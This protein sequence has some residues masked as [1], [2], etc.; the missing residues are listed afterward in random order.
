MTYYFGLEYVEIVNQ[1]GKTYTYYRR[2]RNKPRIRL[3]D[4]SAGKL[5]CLTAWTAAQQNDQPATVKAKHL[6]GP[7]LKEYIKSRGDKITRN[8]REQYLYLTGRIVKI[9]GRV[10]IADVTFEQTVEF[11]EHFESKK[12]AIKCLNLLKSAFR[13]FVQM[14]YLPYSDIE[15][16]PKPNVSAIGWEAW[17][18]KE[19]ETFRNAYPCETWE[20]LAFEIL[21]L[22]GCRISDAIRLNHNNIENNTLTYISKKSGVEAWVPIGNHLELFN[23][24]IDKKMPVFYHPQTGRKFKNEQH[25]SYFFK[26][27]CRAIG[28]KKTTHGLRKNA[29]ITYAEAGLSASELCA[30]LGWK[31]IATAQIYVKYADRKKLAMNAIKNIVKLDKL[32]DS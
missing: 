19:K 27:A 32:D 2:D 25:F 8:T 6:L 1:N 31:H 18:E 4:P 21:S 20:R 30:I 7:M 24:V 3:P 17:T 14:R 16:V 10:S 11:L 26:K 23:H 28:I 29:A 12:V 5:A 9:Y 22:T 13:W 15:Q